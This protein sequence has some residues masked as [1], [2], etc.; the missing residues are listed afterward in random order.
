[1]PKLLVVDD[2]IGI[3]NLLRAFFAE[4]G[5]DVIIANNGDEAVLKIKQERPH[6]VFLDVKM[7]GISGIEVLRHA[8]ELDESIKV[9]MIT[10]VEEEEVVCEARSLGASDYVTKPFSLEYLEGT[11]LAKLNAQLYEELRASNEELRRS[12]ERL[13]QNIRQM[14][15]TL[16]NIVEA[17]DAY[18]GNHQEAVEKIGMALGR[19]LKATSHVDV[20]LETLEMGLHLHDIGKEGIPESI[21][22][23]PDKLT[24]EEWEIM[25]QHPVIGAKILE[26]IEEFKKVTYVTLHHQE[27]YDGTGYPDGLKGDEI[28]IEA[29]I[30]AVADAFHAMT[31]DRPY[32]K[33]P[34]FSFAVSELKKHS[35]TQFDPIVVQMFLA[36]IDEG[37]ISETLTQ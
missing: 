35:G 20:D 23:K 3:C 24:P 14:V 18:T 28:P 2:E 19:R 17:K 13:K 21:L 30:I 6:L 26:P 5:Y 12:Y 8:K 31:S 36:L 37:T 4:K 25:K 9:I 11:V 32:R 1:M 33:A 10:A 29:R 27:K 15:L 22:N 7:P 34:G 16:A